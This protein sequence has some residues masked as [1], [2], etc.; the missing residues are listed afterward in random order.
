MRLYIVVNI[1][2]MVLPTVVQICPHRLVCY[3]SLQTTYGS[4]RVIHHNNSYYNVNVSIQLQCMR[5]SFP[6]PPSHVLAGN[7]T[8]KTRIMVLLYNSVGVQWVE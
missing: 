3:L 2:G 5:A 4:W 1:M 6:E 7:K 8:I